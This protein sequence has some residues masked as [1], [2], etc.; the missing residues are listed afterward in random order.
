MLEKTITNT[1]LK[2]LRS[3][4]DCFCWKQP[5]GQFSTSGLPDI[6]CCYKGR[7]MAFEVKN[8]TGKATKLQEATIRRI[9][10]AGGTASVVRSL[11]EVKT[12][13]ENLG[14]CK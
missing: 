7:F 5:G 2:Y 6:I 13:I 10:C 14:G 1:I 3:L 12:A 8:E 11:D 9:T 4:P